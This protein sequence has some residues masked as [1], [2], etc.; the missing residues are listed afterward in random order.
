MRSEKRICGDGHH[1]GVRWQGK[2]QRKI[3]TE[4]SEKRETRKVDGRVL[5][6]W[7]VG[8]T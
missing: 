6:T 5:R 8:L 1:L 2:S 7:V 3:E 4:Q